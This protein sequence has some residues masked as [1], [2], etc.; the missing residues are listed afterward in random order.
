M[1]VAA[2]GGHGGVPER[3]L[4]QVDGRTPVEAVAGVRMAQ[5]VRRDLSGE[6]GPRGGG[7]AD[8]PGPCSD[9]LPKRYTASTHPVLGVLPSA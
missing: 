5:P 9:L 7:L 4:D 6:A 8:S 3:L 1:E 2:R